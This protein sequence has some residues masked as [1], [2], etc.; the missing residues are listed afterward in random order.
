MKLN[1]L[2]NTIFF[3]HFVPSNAITQRFTE[4]EKY[5]KR[6]KLSRSENDNRTGI[7][8]TQDSD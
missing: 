5:K 4:Y 6:V 3:N 2:G 7:K 8:K 1:H